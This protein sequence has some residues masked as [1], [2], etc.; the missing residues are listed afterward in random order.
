MSASQTDETT[1]I[2]ILNTPFE[3]GG[4]GIPTSPSPSNSL[5]ARLDAVNH[6]LT[7]LVDANPAFYLSPKCTVLRKG[8]NGGYKFNRIQVLGDERFKDVPDKNRFSHPH[9]ALQYACQGALSGMVDFENGNE[10][11]DD[12]DSNQGRSSAG[13]Y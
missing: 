1:C 2:D 9:D 13:G 4:V 3:D 8:F 5:V 6:F 11:Y 10:I 7:K 12:F